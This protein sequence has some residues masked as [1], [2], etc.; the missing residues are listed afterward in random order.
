MDEPSS[1]SA[2]PRA[3]GVSLTPA[4]ISPPLPRE[5]NAGHIPHSIA[6]LSLP[7]NEKVGNK[8]EK[9]YN[10]Q[11]EASVFHLYYLI[12]CLNLQ[13]PA[14]KTP[15]NYYQMLKMMVKT[16]TNTH[17]FNVSATHRRH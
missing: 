4:G 7:G 1:R 14:K 17:V 6:S 3:P 15:A 9:K 13:S 10:V 8:T 2:S 12:L 11:D 16:V 5:E